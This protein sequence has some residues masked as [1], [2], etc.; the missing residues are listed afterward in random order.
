MEKTLVIIKPDAVKLNHIGEIISIYESNGLSIS[1]M[2]MMKATEELLKKHYIEHIE[3]SFY[4]SLI[5]FMLSGKI[6]VLEVTG[7]KAVS[8]VREL[9]GVT[10]SRNAAIGTVRNL[11]G[12]DLQQNAV[13]GSAT[14]GDSSKELE[15][16]FKE[17]EN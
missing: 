9:N 3:K 5:E 1:K 2:K 11:F 14:A 7:E 17:G 10:D 15:I 13:H 6:V 12:T 8:K 4:P 16:W